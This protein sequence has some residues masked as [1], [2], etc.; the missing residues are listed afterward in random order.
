MEFP[1]P[2]VSW[3]E[4]WQAFVSAIENGTE[5]MGNG[6]DGYRANRMIEAVYRSA[7]TGRTVRI[8]G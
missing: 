2:D 8:G 3:R 4:E 1:G 5:P 6:W 7:R